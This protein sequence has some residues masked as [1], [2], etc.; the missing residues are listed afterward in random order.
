MSQGN[1]LNNVCFL[2]QQKHI[3]IIYVC[4]QSTSSLLKLPWR[5]FII[6][7]EFSFCWLFL[8]L[9]IDFVLNNFMSSR[10]RIRSLLVAISSFQR[11]KSKYVR[12][13]FNI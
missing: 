10:L 6:S 2:K 9:M 4:V 13:E 3:V 11:S 7:E 12:K 1:S 8:R 5:L